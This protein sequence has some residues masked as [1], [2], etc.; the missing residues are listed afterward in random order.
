MSGRVVDN[1]IDSNVEEKTTTPNGKPAWVSAFRSALLE[2][3]LLNVVASLRYANY[4]TH[5]GY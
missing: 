5:N 3:G 4:G 1:G 2:S